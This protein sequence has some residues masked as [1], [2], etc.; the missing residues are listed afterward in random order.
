MT[1][2]PNG[3]LYTGVTANLARRSHEHRESLCEGF[4]KQYALTQLVWYESYNDLGA[5]IQRES[6][7]KHWPRAGKIRSIQAINPESP[8]LYL[9]LN[10]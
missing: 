6:N 4:T 1:N 3:T 7:M 2:R 8:D 10:N 9:D 5:A